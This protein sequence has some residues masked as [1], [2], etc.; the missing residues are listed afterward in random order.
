[1]LFQHKMHNLHSV[2]SPGY[3]GYKLCYQEVLK[4]VKGIIHQP[5]QLQDSSVFYAF[6]YYFDRAVDAGLIGECTHTLCTHTLHN[7][8]QQDVV[9]CFYARQENVSHLHPSQ[10][11]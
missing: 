6:S 4:V 3:T 5:Y 7:Y 2:S 8:T 9:T 10:W 1:M 11:S